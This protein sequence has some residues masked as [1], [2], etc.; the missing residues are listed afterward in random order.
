MIHQVFDLLT[1]DQW[2]AEARRRL[3]GRH[4]SLA[5]QLLFLYDHLEG[6]A[7]S[8]LEFH[9]VARFIIYLLTHNT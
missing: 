9:P 2:V 5:E 1:V 8:E 3:E 6:G 7:K 4:M